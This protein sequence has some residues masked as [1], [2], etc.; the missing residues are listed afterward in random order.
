MGLQVY[1][2]K[3]V[4]FFPMKNNLLTQTAADR[5]FQDL[6]FQLLHIE[7]EF[8]AYFVVVERT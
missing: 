2:V 7:C 8:W 1:A 5:W 4:L 6:A 3:G